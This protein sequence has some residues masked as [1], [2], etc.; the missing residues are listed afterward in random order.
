MFLFEDMD[1][2]TKS[3]TTNLVTNCSRK[4]IFNSQKKEV[5]SYQITLENVSDEK[6]IQTKFPTLI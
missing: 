4:S 6:R 2:M 3:L 1:G 5:G